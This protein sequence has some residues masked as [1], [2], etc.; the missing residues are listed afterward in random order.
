VNSPEAIEGIIRD[1]FDDVALLIG[2]AA[3]LH[4]FEDGLV[5][6]LVRRLDRVRARALSRLAGPGG[7]TRPGHPHPLHPAVEKFLQRSHS[8]CPSGQKEEAHA[9]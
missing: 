4:H 5:R 6:I 1:A 9:G 3:T 7:G 8:G 2:G